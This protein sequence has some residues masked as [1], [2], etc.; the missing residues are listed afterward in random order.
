MPN[1]AKLARLEMFINNTPVPPVT[2]DDDARQGGSLD[3]R[4]GGRLA[5]VLHISQM[6]IKNQNRVGMNRQPT[7]YLTFCCARAWKSAICV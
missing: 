4:C 1:C 7:S 6:T 2:G 5:T 3:S